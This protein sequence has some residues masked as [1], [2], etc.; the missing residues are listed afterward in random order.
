[1]KFNLFDT[2]SLVKAI[3]LSDSGTA[4]ANTVG[5][6]VEILR[7]GEAYLVE[8]FGDWVKYDADENLIPASRDELDAFIETI[9]V[10]MVR[11]QQIR[12]LKP[13]SETVGIRARL[14]ALIDAMP[15]PLLQEVADFAES[16]QNKAA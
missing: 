7:D 16:L 8:L 5:A 9:S 6:I 15:D 14:L 12:L 13:A 2:V 10:E 4:P 3:P 11:P 1:M